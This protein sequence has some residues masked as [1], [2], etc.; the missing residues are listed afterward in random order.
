LGGDFSYCSLARK[1][2]LETFEI[3]T[4][5][6]LDTVEMFFFSNTRLD[7]V[8]DVFEVNKEHLD[9]LESKSRDMVF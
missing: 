8:D 2:G 1:H 3:G 4:P 7:D 6:S 5:V 9:N